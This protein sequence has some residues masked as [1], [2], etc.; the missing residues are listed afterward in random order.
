MIRARCVVPLLVLA[1]LASACRSAP[2]LP[3]VQANDNRVTAGALNAD[4]LTLRLVVDMARWYPETEQGPYADMAAFAVEG[5]APSVPAPMI[6]VRTGTVIDVSVRNALADS[7]ITVHGLVTRPATSADSVSIAPGAS[8]RFVFAAGEPGTYLYFARPGVIDPNYEREQLVGAFIVDDES[9]PTDDRVLVMNIWA[10]PGRDSEEERLRRGY[11]NALAVNGLAYPYNEAV[12]AT[13]GED[14]RW[15]VI[16]ATRRPHPMHLHGFYYDVEADGD[17][18]TNTAY[19]PE[20]TRH[21]VTEDMDA[22]GTMTI[23][24]SPDRDGNWLFHCHL[25]FH[26]ASEAARLRPLG[27]VG[28]IEPARLGDQDV[29]MTGLAIAINVTYPPGESAAPSVASRQLRLFVQEGEARG[30]APRAMGYVLERDGRQPSRDSLE[31]PGST[32]VLT[33]DEPTD[34]VV[35]NRLDEP[36]GLHWHGLEL[37]SYFDGIAGFSGN[38]A[39]LAPQIAPADS[40]TARLLLPKAGTFI[41]HTHLNDIEQLTSGLYGPLIVMDPGE[42]FDPATDHIVTAS[43]DGEPVPGGFPPLLVNGGTAPAEPLVVRAGVQQR[44]RFI[45]IAPAA[46]FFYAIRMGPTAIPLR[47]LAKDGA[48]LPEAQRLE[49][50]TP[51]RLNVGETVDVTVTFERGDY[52]LVVNNPADASVSHMQPISVR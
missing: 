10:D 6:R 21:V 33:R 44:F 14:I 32:L 19:A 5:E 40:F 18:W 24:W 52:E 16:N 31:I 34:I 13:V 47:L 25:V 7:T 36:T 22:F 17:P 15:R 48:D 30:A 51:V 3:V 9:G 37:E 1:L 46:R 28:E 35:V 50:A 38:G 45:N 8:H 26:V 2:D 27:H 4:T 41:Y 39:R 42:T 49:T 23:R 12:T 20:E 43:W 29:H 11:R